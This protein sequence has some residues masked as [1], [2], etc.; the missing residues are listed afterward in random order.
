MPVAVPTKPAMRPYIAPPESKANVEYAQLR[1]IDLS[2]F[3]SPDT[4]VRDS[5]FE[6]FKKAIAED[7]FLY[8]VNFG[9]TQEQVRLPC[10]IAVHA[11]NSRSTR[12]S[13][14]RNML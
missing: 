7:G 2:K 1:T 9:L 13:P 5:L 6:D 10:G 14:L 12:S 8:L 3:D 11:L 4:D